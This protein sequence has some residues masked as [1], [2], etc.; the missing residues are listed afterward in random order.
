[1]VHCRSV[2]LLYY[3]NNNNLIHDSS[4]SLLM[5]DWSSFTMLNL[6]K[7]THKNSPR[8]GNQ[9]RPYTNVPSTLPQFSNKHDDLIHRYVKVGELSKA[10]SLLSQG[11]CNIPTSVSTLD[12]LRNKFPSYADVDQEDT[13]ITRALVES[14]SLPPHVENILCMLHP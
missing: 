1:M 7:R 14:F 3:Y 11:N 9:S 2:I 13:G 6:S 12:T 5:D 8:L 10:M 4:A